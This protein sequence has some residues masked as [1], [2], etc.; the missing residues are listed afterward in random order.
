M[1]KRNINREFV[2]KTIYNHRPISRT[3]I[4]KI[5]GLTTAAITKIVNEFL[6]IGIVKETSKRKSFSGRKP[7]FIDI[8]SDSYFIIGVYIA[9]KS[10]SGII[11]NLN[12]DILKRVVYNKSLLENPNLLDEVIKLIDELLKTSGINKEKILGIGMAVPGPIN[13]K[14]GE[15]IYRNLSEGPPY[16]WVRVP[17]TEA[18]LEKFGIPVFAD[19][20]S[21]ASA[22][23]ESWFG[24]GMEFKNF[25]LINFGEAVGGGL[26]LKSRL[27]R[28]EDDIVGEIG[29]NTVDINGPKC[30]CGN[31]GCLELFTK[32]EAIIEKY[33]ILRKKYPDSELAKKQV[34]NVE[35]IYNFKDKNDPIY[36]EILDYLA[37]Y[38]GTGIIN[39]INTLNP[40][41]VIIV[42]NEIDKIDINPLLNRIRDFVK[43]RAYPI[44]REKVKIIPGRLGNDVQLIGSISLVLRDF[45]NLRDF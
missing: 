28:G 4:A 2:L 39:M 24:N 36:N 31:Y 32:N 6:E 35:G 27:Y 15:V 42:T 20:D 18:V 5:T 3:D 12:A 1:L 7:V 11:T 30:E 13:S 38:L 29:H 21:N 34:T 9:R 8:N 23:G 10:I 37:K 16:V 43:K 45:F 19:N 22:V 40:Q 17:L 41:A 14:N 25:I 26:I 33:N 44:V